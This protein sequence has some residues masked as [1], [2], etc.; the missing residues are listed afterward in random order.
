MPST[1]DS[2]PT[3]QQVRDRVSARRAATTPGGASQARALPLPAWR[4]WLRAVRPHQWAKNSLMF[5]PALAAHLPLAVSL[6]SRL[7]LG[8]VAFSSLASGVYLLNDVVDLSS[9]RSHPRKK[10]RPIAAGEID[11]VQALAVSVTLVAVSALLAVWLNGAF[12]AVLALYLLISTVY[13]LFLKEHVIIDV[14][15]LATLYTV[16]IV[17]GATLVG[18]PLSRWFLAFSIFLF[19]SLALVKRAVE[20]RGARHRGAGSVAGRGYR[21]ADAGVLSIV[22]I[23]SATAAALVYCLYITGDS[24]LTLYSRPDLLWLGLPIFLYWIIR[25]WL[26]ALRGDLHE[27]SVV[28]ALRDPP[29]YLALAAFIFTVWI[30]S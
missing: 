28:F 25:I 15:T 5:L 6:V 4:P 13:S 14:I 10:N 18:V 1:V 3:G 8:F 2:G 22:G 20:L 19:L 9:D 11:S 24:V 17:A 16:R 23:S 29:T 26:L 12:A 27:D 30:A 21:S 7:A